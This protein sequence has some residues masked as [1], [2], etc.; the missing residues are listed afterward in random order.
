MHD[1]S[2]YG[3]PLADTVASALGD[4]AVGNVSINIDETDHSAALSQVADLEPEAV[5]FGGYQ[6]EFT[7]ILEQAE[8]QG[9]EALFTSGDGSKAL[10]LTEAKS[11]QGAV[12]F[13]PCDDPAVSTNPEAKQFATDFEAAVGEPPG[14]YAIEGFDGVQMVVAALVDGGFDSGSD[15]AEIREGIKSFVADGTYEGLSKTFEFDD[16]GEI[17]TVSIFAYQ[18]ESDGFK[19]LGLVSEL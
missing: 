6:P 4:A 5:F 1:N 16:T 10:E 8:N 7:E 18:V 13:C 11:A 17:G 19:Q 9:I 12:V 15:M 2:E 3:K 14:T